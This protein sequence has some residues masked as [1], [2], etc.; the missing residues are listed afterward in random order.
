M[1]VGV[2]GASEKMEFRP[3][4]GAMTGSAVALERAIGRQIGIPV[5]LVSQRWKEIEEAMTEAP[6]AL[7]L[8]GVQA[9]KERETELEIRTK[10]VEPGPLEFEP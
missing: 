1:P 3:E 4:E 6:F 7:E 9:Q 10:V 2:K 8:G 5:R